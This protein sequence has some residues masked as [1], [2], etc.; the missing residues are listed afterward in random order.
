M[1]A[2][3]PLFKKKKPIPDFFVLLEQQCQVCVEGISQLIRYMEETDP[4]RRAEYFDRVGACEKE[5]DALRR[6]LIQGVESSFFTPF[7]REDIYSLSRQIDDI[8]DKVD[9]LKE[10]LDFF[11]IS[12]F[13][14]VLE[15]ANVALEAME[16][17][18]TFAAE[19]KKPPDDDCWQYLIKAKKDENRAKRIYWQSVIDIGNMHAPTHYLLR[20]RELT[21]DMNELAN[22]IAKAADKMSEVKMKMIK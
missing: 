4:A 9:E 21:K 22:K 7:D 5:A 17:V 20:M 3:S 6:E 12:A 14:S 1:S 18:K 15:I 13:S 8:M 19:L 10:M 16:N 2:K 11:Q